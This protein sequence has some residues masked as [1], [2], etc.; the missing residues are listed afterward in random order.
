MLTGCVHCDLLFE[1]VHGAW[2]LALRPGHGP[3]P[4]AQRRG[5]YGFPFLRQTKVACQSSR[6]LQKAAARPPL[7]IEFQAIQFCSG[8]MGDFKPQQNLTL[9]ILNSISWH[10]KRCRELRSN[11]IQR[12]KQFATSESIRVSR[13]TRALKRALAAQKAFSLHKLVACKK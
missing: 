10:T 9:V 8:S 2:L 7:V 1:Q 3:I 11:P 6:P 13:R 4:K 12:Q 5:G